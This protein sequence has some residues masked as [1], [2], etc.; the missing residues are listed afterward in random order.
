MKSIL[1][2]II[3][4]VVSLSAFAQI[5]KKEIRSGNNLYEKEKYLDS[6]VK[7]RKALEK[8][9]NS[10]D[11]MFN[12]GDALYKQGKHEESAKVFNDML[13]L[14]RPKDQKDKLAN[15]LYNLGNSLLKA[16]KLDES[17]QAYKNSLRANPSDQDA[18]YNLAYAMHMKKKNDQ[19]KKND[20][21]DKNK[22][23]NKDKNNKD[24]KDNKD[25]K[26]NKDKN[27]DQNNQQQPNQ[28]PKI[29]KDDAERI[30]NA[31]QNNEKRAQEK[32][33]EKKGQ[34]VKVKVQKNW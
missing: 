27:D 20:K 34:A 3:I 15:A 25:N 4:I 24:Q 31:L 23:K 10:V 16:N 32:A 7:Y 6:E 30:L 17:I 13:P 18:K 22:D 8:N 21:N 19:D 33:N 11:A 14:V 29:S 28:Q 12:L 26:G 5:E 1:T 9:P 2:T